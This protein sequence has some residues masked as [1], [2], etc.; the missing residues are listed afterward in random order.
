MI[1]P[2]LHTW[3]LRFMRLPFDILTGFSL[4]F[5]AATLSGPASFLEWPGD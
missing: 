2:L 5:I 1:L 3:P 4:M